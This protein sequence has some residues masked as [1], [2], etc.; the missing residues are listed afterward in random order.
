MSS[1]I[2]NRHS[3]KLQMARMVFFLPSKS[4]I[5][6]PLETPLLLKSKWI[7]QDPLLSGGLINRLNPQIVPIPY[8]SLTSTTLISLR[9][10]NYQVSNRL[11]EISLL[12]FSQIYSLIHMV[13]IAKWFNN[14]VMLR[15]QPVCNH[16]NYRVQVKEGSS[17]QHTVMASKLNHFKLKNKLKGSLKI[18]QLKQLIWQAL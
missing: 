3:I 4:L 16:H 10:L 1:K 11:S 15:L 6:N 5:I 14:L 2:I 7:L 9:N 13:S 18:Y 17:I 8:S 12:A